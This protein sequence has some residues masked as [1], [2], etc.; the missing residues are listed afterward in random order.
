MKKIILALVLLMVY[1]LPPSWITKKTV[2][3]SGTAT[4]SETNQIAS[5][6]AG[7]MVQNYD[8]NKAI[9]EVNNKVNELI[10]VVKEFGVENGDIQTQSLSYYQEPK[11]G[12]NP[13]QWEV[14]NTVEITLRDVSLASKLADLLAKTG[15]TN[16]YGPNFRL[17]ENNNSGDDLFEE[18]IKDAKIKAE[19]MAKASGRKLG[20]VIS[21]TEGAASGGYPIYDRGYG[22]AELE[23]GSVTVSKTV[24]V[25]WELK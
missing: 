3:V 25:V 21:V 2:T 11:G 16:V 7:V 12:A 24:M 18:A 15:A 4:T 6:S 13:G 19:N 22:G 23:P 14:N 20:K 17:R 9:E 10:K 1:I 5:F 8:K